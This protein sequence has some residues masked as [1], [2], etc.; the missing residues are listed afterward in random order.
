V[1]DIVHVVW[2]TSRTDV[3]A[4][5]YWDQALL[6]DLLERACW[7]PAHALHYEQVIGFDHLPDGQGAVVVVPGRMEPTADWLA[8]RVAM[9]P[10]ALV[11]VTSDEEGTFPWRVLRN[12]DHPQLAVWVQTPH[13]ELHHDADGFLPVGYPTGLREAAEQLVSAGDRPLAWSF[14]GQI[15]HARRRQMVAAARDAAG[16]GLLL[17]T[18]RF[19]DGMP[20]GAYWGTLADT[21]VAPCPGGPVTPDTF[22][23]WEALH[24]GAVPLIDTEAGERAGMAGYW[25][26]LLRGYE[27]APVPHVDAWPELP[28][29]VDAAT[30]AWPTSANL[31]G[32]W[33]I[34][35]QR[36]LAYALD[37]TVRRLAQLDA[38]PTSLRDLITVVVP[39]SPVPGNPSTRHLVAT[40]LSAT[41]AGLQDCEVI[42]TCDGVREEQRHLAEPYAHAVHQLVT[43]AT[44]HWPNVLPVVHGTHQHQARMLADALRLVR[45]P[46]VLYLEHDTPLEGTIPWEQLARTLLNTDNAAGTNVA[47]LVRFHHEAQVLDEHRYLM[48]DTG[49]QLV[50]PDGLLLE[51]CQQWSQ[52]PHLARADYYRRILADHFDPDERHMIEDRMH[53]VLQTGHWTDHRV[54][55]YAEPE[56]ERGIRRSHHLDARGAEPKWV[57]T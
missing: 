25:D 33:W 51:R 4:R 8:D 37:D 35:Y 39:T 22:R 9:L 52:R 53:S 27:R 45:T 50:G 32:A 42:V 36:H 12:L 57:D 20:Q 26:L 28:A 46:L 48:P 44:H 7:T 43:D 56:A 15:T 40:L 54:W 16:D 49:P 23:V 14:A 18:D 24:L 30:G 38:E 2:A 47:N 55:M 29:W 3:A 34:G 41:V 19:A 10:W 6:I 5:G 11:I 17:E 31:A 13:P 1:T 21:Q